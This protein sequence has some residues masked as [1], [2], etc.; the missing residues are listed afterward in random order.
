MHR[1]PSPCR[2]RRAR[3][4]DRSDHG[5]SA[6]GGSVCGNCRRAATS[7]VQA[8]RVRQSGPCSG[9]RRNAMLCALSNSAQQRCR[10]W[11]TGK[12]A[13]SDR[14]TPYSKAGPEAPPETCIYC[15]IQTSSLA[16]PAM[17]WQPY[18]PHGITPE[19]TRNS[20]RA[21]PPGTDT[22]P[23]HLR[24]GSCRSRWSRMLPRFG[25]RS[26]GPSA[27]PRAGTNCGRRP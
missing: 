26:A 21:G 5:S 11:S 23:G 16:C 9:K 10:A 24:S 1:R 22:F 20:H 19:R 14:R 15:A 13:S 17:T 18:M 2:K 7:K 25:A 27:E 12:T 6:Y 4:A 8:V 3:T